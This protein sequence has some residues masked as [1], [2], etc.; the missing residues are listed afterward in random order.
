[1]E[2]STFQIYLIT[3]LDNIQIISVLLSLTF[4]IFLMV[5]TLFI[6]IEDHE[7]GNESNTK[8]AKKLAKVLTILLIIFVLAATFI[9]S[10]KQTAFIILAPKVINNEEVQKLPQN[11]LQFLNKK[12]ESYINDLGGLEQ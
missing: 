4:F 11:A 5:V 6:Y 3:I 8:S 2:I 7:Y 10:T 1:M 9:P 12:M